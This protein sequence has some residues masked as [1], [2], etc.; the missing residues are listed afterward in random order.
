MKNARD[1]Y[2][3]IELELLTDYNI[4]YSLD[5]PLVDISDIE[6]GIL[7]LRHSRFDTHSHIIQG[8]CTMK[9]LQEQQFIVVVDWQKED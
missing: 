7:I 8:F 4:V 3:S 5:W 2:P 1:V 9:I 6:I